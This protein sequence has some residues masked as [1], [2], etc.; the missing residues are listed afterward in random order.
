MIY[1]KNNVGSLLQAIFEL[2]PRGE[3]LFWQ[4][5]SFIIELKVEKSTELE[6]KKMKKDLKKET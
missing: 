3:N 2:E 5:N 6:T 4:Q 1:C